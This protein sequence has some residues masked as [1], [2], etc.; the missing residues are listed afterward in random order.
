MYPFRF[1]HK[2]TSKRARRK[3]SGKEWKQRKTAATP[4]S[5]PHTHTHAHNIIPRLRQQT[6]QQRRTPCRIGTAAE[7]SYLRRGVACVQCNRA[8]PCVC[9][10]AHSRTYVANRQARCWPRASAKGSTMRNSYG[11]WVF[12]FRYLT[13]KCICGVRACLVAAA[14]GWAGRWWWTAANTVTRLLVRTATTA[15]IV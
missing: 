5:Q 2:L 9:A 11:A 3:E 15:K 10:R 1:S 14:R 13:N 8:V 7:L 6:P 4:P 12:L